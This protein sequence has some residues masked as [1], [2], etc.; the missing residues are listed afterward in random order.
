MVDPVRD[1]GPAT[2]KLDV[3]RP[4]DAGGTGGHGR[5]AERTIRRDLPEL[6]LDGWPGSWATC[7][8]S[9]F[10]SVAGKRI[11]SGLLRVAGG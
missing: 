6:W 2:L 7:G 9:F 5:A 3:V 4:F 11:G 8:G 1:M 10:G